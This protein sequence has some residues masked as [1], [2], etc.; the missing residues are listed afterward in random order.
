MTTVTVI[1]SDKLIIVNNTPLV[2]DFPAPVNLHALQWDGARGHM[3]WTDDDNWPLTEPSAYEDEVAPYVA[4][5]QAEK[6]RLEQEEAAAEAA[7]QA[8]YNKLENVKARKLA[9][10]DADTSAAILAGFE[11][12]ADAGAGPER[13]HFSY[14]AFDQQNFAD[15]ANASML[16][17]SGAE[18]LPESVTWNAYRN[19][20]AE[21][22]GE[23][24]RLT[25]TPAEFLALYVAGALAHKAACMEAGGRRKA[26][27]EAAA[28]AE[29]VESA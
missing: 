24:V 22:G 20:A 4:L 29:E 25:F 23:L 11:Y 13:L 7:F 15:T 2:F 19:R 10:I 28:T 14:D 21:H 26:A 12:A 18:G 1:P 27:V 9:Q 3:E 16:A 8:E 5:W 6:E 17:Q